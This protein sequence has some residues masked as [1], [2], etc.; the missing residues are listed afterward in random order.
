MPGTEVAVQSAGA[1]EFALSIASRREQC[2]SPGTPSGTPGSAVTAELVTDGAHA[3]AAESNA[4]AA[5]AIPAVKIEVLLTPPVRRYTC[6]A[7]S[8][9]AFMMGKCASESS[10]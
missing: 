4:A 9:R 3:G 8:A 10:P 6:A 1:P 7:G 5:T 2:P